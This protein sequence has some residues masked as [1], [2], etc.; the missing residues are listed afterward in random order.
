MRLNIRIRQEVDTDFQNVYELISASF[1]R[2]NEAKLVD[3]LRVSNALVPALSLVALINN[4]IVGHILLSK[5]VIINDYQTEFESLA[6]APLSVEP[7]YQKRGIGS[8]LIKAGIEKAKE[9][10]FKSV[11][12]L[13]HKA[14]YPKF[15]FMPAD[16]W[17]IKAPF[18]VNRESFMAIELVTDGLKNVSGIVKYP[19]EFDNA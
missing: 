19:K 9:L 11:I 12:V 10:N 1:G 17:S 16:K 2:E 15:G 5:I 6:L 14:Y 8:T 13:G 7:E 3:N 4:K 18:T